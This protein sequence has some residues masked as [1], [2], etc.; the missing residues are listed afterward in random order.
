MKTDKTTLASLVDSYGFT[1]TARL[2]GYTYEYIHMIY[3]G[4][5]K[6]TKNFKKRI[7]NL[8]P[9]TRHLC[10]VD[11][12]TEEDKEKVQKLSMQ[13]RRRVLLEAVS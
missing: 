2:L 4:K 8:T 6:P 13:T 9:R 12:L 1:K 11:M 7:S 3:N 5:M 10:A